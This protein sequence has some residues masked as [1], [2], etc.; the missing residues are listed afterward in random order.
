MRVVAGTAKGRRLKSPE[1][2]GTRPVMDRVKTALFDILA[3]RVQDAQFLDLFGGTGSIGIEALSRGASAATFVELERL[4]VTCI[5][6]NLEITGFTGKSE[7]WRGDAFTYL[8]RA[9]AA[10]KRYDIIYIAPPQY[11]GLAARALSALD[12]APLTDHDGLVIAQIHPRERSDL[13][14]LPLAC[15]TLVDERRYGS[16]LLLFFEHHTT[17]EVMGGGGQLPASA[18]QAS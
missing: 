18:A 16:T 13:D 8:E 5:R 15:L 10:G 17:G 9:S 12:A 11:H 4:A 14:G 7:V 6:D 3:S 1:T 2:K